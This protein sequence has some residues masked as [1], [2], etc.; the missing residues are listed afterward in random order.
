M[1]LIRELESKSFSKDKLEVCK[2]FFAQRPWTLS[3]DDFVKVFNSFSFGKDKVE[4]AKVIGENMGSCY[5]EAMAG[6]VK[7]CSF[8]GDKV[9][10]I[11]AFSPSIQ[12][13]QNVD[14]VFRE[15]SFDSE[16]E[17]AAA[18]LGKNRQNILSCSQLAAVLK[19][20]KSS[21]TQMKMLES[22]KGIVHPNDSNKQAVVDALSFSS[23]KD[24]AKKLLRM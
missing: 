19:T 16:K 23:D 7:S 15:L 6:A 12:S 11:E 17:E 14:L 22:L 10:V 24:K 18:A 9:K 20:S 8:G 5:C 4:A 13:F 1:A 3:N 21:S 2:K